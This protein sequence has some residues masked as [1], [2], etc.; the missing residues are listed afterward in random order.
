MSVVH[1]PP[2]IESPH[3]RNE[4]E[5]SATASNLRRRLPH[6][7]SSL[8]APSGA[9]HTDGLESD[10]PWRVLVVS[11]LLPYHRIC[12][13]RTCWRPGARNCSEPAPADGHPCRRSAT[14]LTVVGGGSSATRMSCLGPW[15]PRRMSSSRRRAHCGAPSP[16]LS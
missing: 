12:P 14:L 3:D 4:V 1:L 5:C 7:E 10:W 11:V 13:P 6:A 15:T 2:E 16:R 8:P 9:M